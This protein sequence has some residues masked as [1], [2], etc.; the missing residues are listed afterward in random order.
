MENGRLDLSVEANIIKTEYS[1]LFSREV[2]E[3]YYNLKFGFEIY[4]QVMKFIF[5]LCL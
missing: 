1:E 4:F 3:K 5:P 2:I